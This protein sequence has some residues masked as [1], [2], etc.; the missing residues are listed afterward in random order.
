MNQFAERLSLNTYKIYALSGETQSEIQ[1]Q[2]GIFAASGAPLTPM[3]KDLKLTDAPCVTVQGAAYHFFK[4]LR[5][6]HF[7]A[8][9]FDLGL[10]ELSSTTSPAITAQFGGRGKINVITYL[11]QEYTLVPRS[12]F[13]FGFE[14][15]RGTEMVARFKDV[16]PFLSFSS[17]RRYLIDYPTQPQPP[18]LVAF[19]FLLAVNCTYRL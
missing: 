14:L 5:N 4:L 16:S 2:R 15:Y 11:D 10:Q 12:W 17:R 9:R 18:L 1:L 6:D 13:G 3:L 7:F 8:N 19:T